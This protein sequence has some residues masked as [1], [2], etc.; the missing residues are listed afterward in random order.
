MESDGLGVLRLDGQV[1]EV[2]LVEH[3][4]VILIWTHRCC[5]CG[6]VNL[7][8]TD[9]PIFELGLNIKVSSKTVFPHRYQ[10]VWKAKAP[11]I[12]VVVVPRLLVSYQA[13]R[14]PS[15]YVLVLWLVVGRIN[16]DVLAKTVF[17]Q[18]LEGVL[19]TDVGV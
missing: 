13:L 9:N 17:E 8:K 10:C 7:L 4:E 5:G 16:C 15:Y 6:V 2:N 19:D 1:V 18:D 11:Y 3:L 14:L 12:A